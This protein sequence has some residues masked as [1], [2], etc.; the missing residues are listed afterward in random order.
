MARELDADLL[1]IG[2]V[3]LVGD[4]LKYVAERDELNLWEVLT[5]H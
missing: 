1:V 2:S 5:A 4:L 3:Y